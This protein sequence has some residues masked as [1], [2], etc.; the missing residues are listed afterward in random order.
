MVIIILIKYI[1][2]FLHD[3]LN[4]FSYHF[5]FFYSADICCFW[6]ASI[7]SSVCVETTCLC[8]CSPMPWR[9]PGQKRRPPW[10]V[11]MNYLCFWSFFLVMFCFRHSFFVA[12]RWRKYF[13]SKDCI[14]LQ[15]TFVTHIYGMSLAQKI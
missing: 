7:L 2:L 9:C 10:W 8:L 5:F 12:H 15:Y 4:S 11:T 6:F 1:I 13:G 14:K 3:K